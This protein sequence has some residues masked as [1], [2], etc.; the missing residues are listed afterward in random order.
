[1]ESNHIGTLK[2]KRKKVVLAKSRRYTEQILT[3]SI[4]VREQSSDF[5]HE[6]M[7]KKSEK[8]MSE[9]IGLVETS[10]TISHIKDEFTMTTTPHLGVK[11]L[12]DD[13]F[14]E[15]SCYYCRVMKC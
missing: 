3:K 12:I 13:S 11:P 2:M 6:E 7:T 15:H 1:M 4:P 8:M 9:D 14:W 5:I 10:E